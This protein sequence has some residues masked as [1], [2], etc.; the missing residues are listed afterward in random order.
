MSSIAGSWIQLDFGTS[1]ILTT[2]GFFTDNAPYAPKSW[3]MAGSNNGTNWY[4][5]D[6]TSGIVW[7]SGTRQDFTPSG[8]FV[9]NSYRYYRFIVQETT[10]NGYLTPTRFYMSFVSGSLD[11]VPSQTCSYSSD[12]TN[13]RGGAIFTINNSSGGTN[14][15]PTSN[16]PSGSY[17]GSVTTSV[18]TSVAPPAPVVPPITNP[19]VFH[20]NMSNATTNLANPSAQT[21][22][23]DPSA[24]VHQRSGATLANSVAGFYDAA[25]NGQ[26]RPNAPPVFSSY[27]Q[28]MAWKQGMNRR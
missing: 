20:S 7:S 15:F 19:P 11:T 3:I 13:G 23:F 28:M 24:L 9:G 25:S 4:Q 8:V 27:Q 12:I 6:T 16:Y 21:A 10:T 26:I 18:I 14:Y 17:S 1:N 5:V 22:N 2:Y